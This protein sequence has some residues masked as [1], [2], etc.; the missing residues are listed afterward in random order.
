MDAVAAAAGRI[1]ERNVGQKTN[2]K[3]CVASFRLCYLVSRTRFSENGAFHFKMEGNTHEKERE[4]K[5][6]NAGTNPTFARLST[7]F[8][9]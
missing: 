8:S 9:I 3:V 1:V 5:S 7:N 6:Q 2:V 4:R